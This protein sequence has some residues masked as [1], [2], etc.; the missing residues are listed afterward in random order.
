MAYWLLIELDSKRRV[1]YPLYLGSLYVRLDEGIRTITRVVGRYDD[2]VHAPSLLQ[3]FSLESFPII[4]PNC[5]ISHSDHKGDDIS[6]WLRKDEITGHVQ[7]FGMEVAKPKA[8]F[9]L[10][11]MKMLDKEENFCIRPYFYTPR[12]IFTPSTIG[13]AKEE[14]KFV[15]K[16]T[17]LPL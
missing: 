7:A 6:G 1:P 12:R 9:Q 14:I 8:T 15:D 5:V 2:A 17:C 4:T 13:E 10:F 16:S 11:L 3:K